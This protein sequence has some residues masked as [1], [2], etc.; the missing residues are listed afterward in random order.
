MTD[1]VAAHVLKDNYDQTGAVGGAESARQDLDAHGRFM[2]ELE[3]AA[4]STA[5]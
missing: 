2:R 3:R 1:D 4:D 5:R